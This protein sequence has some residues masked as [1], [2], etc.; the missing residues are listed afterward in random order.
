VNSI[1]TLAGSFLKGALKDG[2]ITQNPVWLVESEFLP[3]R[4]GIVAG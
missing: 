1:L 4:K 3:A 2:L